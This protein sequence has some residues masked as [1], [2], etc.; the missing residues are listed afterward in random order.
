MSENLP[1]R[2]ALKAYPFNCQHKLRDRYN[3]ISPQ[4]RKAAVCCKPLDINLNPARSL[5]PLTAM[6]PSA[7]RKGKGS[8]VQVNM[9]IQTLHK[10]CVLHHLLRSPVNGNAL[11]GL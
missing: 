11:C 9:S 10:T 3:S 6:A 4:M 2:Q 5:V 8:G 1:Y 7:C